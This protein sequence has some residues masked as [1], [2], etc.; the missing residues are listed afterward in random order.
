MEDITMSLKEKLEKPFSEDELEFRVGATNSDKT[1]GLALAYIQARAIQNRLDEVVGIENWK[2][3]Y[4]EINGGFIAK[5]ELKINNEW[6]AKEDGSG[7]TDYE[8]IKG[9]IS[10]AF[11][12]VASVW[13]IGRY[14]YEVEGQ[15]LPIEQR[16]KS[17]IFKETPKLNKQQ[18]DSSVE[19]SKKDRAKNIEL[20][21]GKYKGKTLGEIFKENKDYLTYLTTNSKDTRIINACKYLL[22]FKEVA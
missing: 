20:T 5:L 3:S 6:I 1:K 22:N 4:K 12:R 16:G 11:K 8:A 18:K 2:V 10:C 15:W 17:Y 19:E 21:F 13:G 7:V 14:L 9:G